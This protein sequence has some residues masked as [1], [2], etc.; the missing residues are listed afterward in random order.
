MTRGS[1]ADYDTNANGTPSGGAGS[2]DGA[3]G[4]R[5]GIRSNSAS[6]E[7]KSEES[8]HQVYKIAEDSR[9]KKDD[10]EMSKAE[11]GNALQFNGVDAERLPTTPAS[12]TAAHIYRTAEDESTNEVEIQ[13]EDPKKGRQTSESP[14]DEGKKE[15]DTEN[16][17]EQTVEEVRVVEYE[18]PD[19]TCVKRLALLTNPYYN[20][21]LG[22]HRKALALLIIRATFVLA[23]VLGAYIEAGEILNENCFVYSPVGVFE[24]FPQNVEAKAFGDLMFTPRTILCSTE[25]FDD[26]LS[27]AMKSPTCNLIGY[28]ASAFFNSKQFNVTF[29]NFRKRATEPYE[30][31]L[32]RSNVSIQQCLKNNDDFSPKDSLVKLTEEDTCGLTAWVSGNGIGPGLALIVTIT[33]CLLFAFYGFG[34]EL[35][36][37]RMIK[38]KDYDGNERFHIWLLNWK[39]R[40]V[41]A[42]PKMVNVLRLFSSNIWYI[43]FVTLSSVDGCKNL[44]TVQASL[45]L[46]ILVAAVALVLIAYIKCPN[47]LM[48]ILRMRR[49]TIL[50]VLACLGGIVIIGQYVTYLVDNWG[51]ITSLISNMSVQDFSKENNLSGPKRIGQ[52]LLR[53]GMKHPPF[54]GTTSF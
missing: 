52:F 26:A 20:A 10:T 4:A 38:H 46:T 48:C 23:S 1:S 32:R 29:I 12:L 42:V 45:P 11:E 28:N 6:V 7:Q 40:N 49:T 25:A 24:N 15:R 31:N 27:S 35:Q 2:N 18:E 5:N 41:A 53:S 44:A 33:T 21:I 47:W 43:A 36:M 9:A 54:Y 3:D 37:V 19:S 16:D 8:R 13:V 14:E 17:T 30:T 22:N 51:Y 50:I 39:Y 34:I